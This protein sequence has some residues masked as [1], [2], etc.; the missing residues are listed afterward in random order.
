MWSQLLLLSAIVGAQKEGQIVALLDK[1]NHCKPLTWA[2]CQN[3]ELHPSLGELEGIG[4]FFPQYFQTLQ[5]VSDTGSSFQYTGHEPYI[6]KL[7]LPTSFPEVP[8]V[9]GGLAKCGKITTPCRWI[10]AFPWVDLRPEIRASV[11]SSFRKLHEVVLKENPQV[12]EVAI[13]FR[14]GDILSSSILYMG[15]IP[16]KAYLKMIPKH[17]KRI[18]II[19]T[20]SFHMGDPKLT[21]PGCLGLLTG[22]H[23]FLSAYYPGARVTQHLDDSEVQSYARLAAAQIAICGISTF[24][25]Y[26]SLM[27]RK[28]YISEHFLGSEHFSGTVMALPTTE[29]LSPNDI[30]TRHG[31]ST[32]PGACG[33][34][35]I[36]TNARW[37]GKNGRDLGRHYCHSDECTC[38][39]K[40]LNVPAIV[41]A[42]AEYPV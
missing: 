2:G 20:L 37:C 14:C 8:E 23:K 28:T 7:G 19:S 40:S 16:F 30:A 9:S 33:D 10:G 1:A 15:F 39:L 5:T 35:N 25:I 32:C 24:C 26:P 41:A 38:Q 42:L 11:Q 34:R 13:H 22:L 3:G 17:T 18:G 27:A 36:P 6:L 12:D 21:K 31:M 29:F 4:I